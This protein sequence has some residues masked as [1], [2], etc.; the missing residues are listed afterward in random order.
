MCVLSERASARVEQASVFLLVA[1]VFPY[2]EES[3]DCFLGVL[4]DSLSSFDFLNPFSLFK[5]Q[6]ML[7][8]VS[9]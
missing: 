6:I 3:I 8:L 5:L 7:S 4:I 9:H 1:V 2:F